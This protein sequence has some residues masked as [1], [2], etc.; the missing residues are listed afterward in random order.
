MRAEPLSPPPSRCT[1]RPL[2]PHTGPQALP[3]LPRVSHPVRTLSGHP[4]LSVT[5]LT[6]PRTFHLASV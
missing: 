3:R 5:L 2:H 4:I 6:A 1:N